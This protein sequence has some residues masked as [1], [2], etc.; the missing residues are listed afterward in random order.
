MIVHLLYEVCVFCVF[1]E[2]SKSSVNHC[3]LIQIA[4]CFLKT[5]T[6]CSL[7]DF[8][9]I[10]IVHLAAYTVKSLYNEC[11]VDGFPYMK[12]RFSLNGGGHAVA[13]LVEAL[14]YKLEGHGFDPKCG[15]GNFS[16]T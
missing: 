8:I 16:L 11:L 2:T 4:L 1:P 15:D 14:C 7:E 13:K 9:H 6:R 12:L 5:S 3:V 10:F